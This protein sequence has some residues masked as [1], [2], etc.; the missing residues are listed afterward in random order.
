MFVIDASGGRPRSIHP[1]FRSARDG[2]W[3][4]DGKYLIFAGCRDDSATSCDCWVTPVE[5]GKPIATGA[6]HRLSGQPSP[7]LWLADNVIVFTVKNVDKGG[8]WILNLEANSWG[9][10]GTPQ[11]LTSAEYDA[12]SPA[13][14][15]DGKILFASRTMNVDLWSLP[16]D[17]DQRCA[18]GTLTRL[19]DDPAIDQRPSLSVDGRRVAWETSRGGNFEVWVKDLVSKKEHG[20]TSGPLREHMPALSRDGSRVVYD[21]HDGEK[22]TIFESAF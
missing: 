12:R 11:R 7:D 6:A 22:V 8:L 13:A 15:P 2:V 4:P 1:E 10:I 20:L 14:S 16:L 17:A 9:A 5:G 19:T 3:S 18:T 21:S